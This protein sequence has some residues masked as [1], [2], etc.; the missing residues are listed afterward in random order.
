MRFARTLSLY[1]MRETLGH[2][3]LA[4]LVLTLIMLTQNL[5][6]RLEELFL[7]GMTPQDVGIA[8]ECILPIVV[9]YSLP[10]AFLVGILLA[11]RRFGSDGEL[12]GVRSAGIGPTM[13]L[14]PL[15]ALGVV[16]AGVS[17][18]LTSTEH[19]SRRDLVQLFKNVAAR[20]AI[21]EAG[22][23]RRIGRRMIFIEDRDRSGAL[24]GVMIFDESRRG[25]PFRIFAKEGRFVFDE[26][27]SQIV[28]ELSTGDL[29]L[30]P[31]EGR[32]GRY[33]RIRFESFSYR[34]D[35]A[36]L[37]GREFGPVRPKQMD[38]DE[39]RAVLDRAEQGDPLRELDQK[40]PVEYALESHRRRTQPLAPLAFAGVGV[41]IALASERR[42]RN[43]G[44]L[45]CLSVAFAYYALGFAAEGL[46]RAAWL[47]PGLASWLPNILFATCGFALAWID[48]RRIPR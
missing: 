34:V 17:G 24:V 26:A 1:V 23:F 25:H 12:E 11:M 20:G 13:L 37:L 36:H 5:L 47:S 28:L 19:Q 18:W 6:R 38:Q 35:V 14:V 15:L 16:A 32:P 21:L 31:D 45:L 27:S 46:A 3:V 41:P 40:N 30:Q 48:R 44:L 8:L 39:L 4:F 2:C 33:E 9:S 7:V 22:K 43:L 29:H 10:V 42:G